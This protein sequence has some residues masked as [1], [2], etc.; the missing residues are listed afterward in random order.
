MK[1]PVLLI[2]DDEH[3][4]KALYKSIIN[5]HFD[6][7][8]IETDS[9]K[10]VELCLKSHKPDYVLLDLC[11]SDGEGFD[12]IPAL[13]KVNPEVKILVITAFN[14]CKEKQRA[15]ELGAIG[16]LAKPFE[17]DTFVEHLKMIQN[18]K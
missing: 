16:L 1:R 5:R 14:H 7:D 12:V 4:I 15:T 11:L 2:V 17:K 13:K 6:F 3:D 10:G 18:A 9:I 8:V